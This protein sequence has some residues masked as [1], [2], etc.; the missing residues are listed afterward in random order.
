VEQR[1]VPGLVI[2]PR[3]SNVLFDLMLSR[4]MR[5]YGADNAQRIAVAACVLIFFWGSFAFVGTAAGG[6]VWWIAPCLVMLSYGWVFHRGFFNFFLSLGLS[7]FALSAWL[8]GRITPRAIALVLLTLAWVAHPLP[9]LWALGVAIAMK[10]AGRYPRVLVPM[11]IAALIAVHFVIAGLYPISWSWDQTALMTGADQFILFGS[12]YRTVASCAL[13]LAGTVIWSHVR[14]FGIVPLSRSPEMQVLGLLSVT[15]LAMPAAIWVP[16][17]RWPLGYLPERMSL[18]VAVMACV[19][20]ARG[21]VARWQA[22]SWWILLAA[23]GMLLYGDTGA[24]NR[25]EDAVAAKV[26]RL[27]PGQRVVI[28]AGIP[29]MRVNML[30]HMVD[31]ACIGHCFSYANYEPCTLEFR[32]R[33][34]ARNYA[35]TANCD[36]SFAMQ[37]GTYI[38]ET[39]DPA[40]VQVNICPGDRVVPT[41]LYPGQLT[42]HPDCPIK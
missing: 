11:G 18:T 17:H 38:V 26:S 16:N 10:L 34:T 13:F 20:M 7:L 42:G 39:D 36:A 4:G 12:A 1:P 37:A 35:V 40:L 41:D 25:L 6:T 23:Y 14:W 5:L 2:V 29:E 30:A 15:I 27:N 28:A 21:P 32:L 22:A 24:L 3:Y 8:T 19:V 31:R 9:V 33:A